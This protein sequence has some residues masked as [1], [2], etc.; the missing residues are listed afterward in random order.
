MARFFTDRP[1]FA[2]VI[3]LF[4]MIAGAL[5]LTRLPVAQY[6]AIAPPT[7]NI[8]VTYPGATADTLDESVT[9][10]IEQELNGIEGLH[11]VES[12]SQANGTAQITATFVPETDPDMAQ[13]EVQNR[14][15]RVEARLPEEVTRQGV[16]VRQSRSNFLM[17]VSL[18]SSDG[19]M[20]RDQI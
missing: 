18:F 7:I 5:A 6:P 16:N 8:S 11:Y 2:W 3:A 13:V 4:I 1:V 19:S 20:T 17:M 12:E 9:S 15:K 10:L 14:I